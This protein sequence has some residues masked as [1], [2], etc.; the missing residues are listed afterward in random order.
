MDVSDFSPVELTVSYDE[1][2]GEVIVEGHLKERTDRMGSIEKHFKRKFALPEDTCSEALA[3]FL[4]TSKNQLQIVAPKKGIASLI[5]PIPIQIVT[6]VPDIS[7]REDRNTKSQKVNDSEIKIEKQEN[8]VDGISK[9]TIN[10]EPKSAMAEEN[11]SAEITELKREPEA[12]ESNAEIKEI[13]EDDTES[14]QQGETP[15]RPRR[16]PKIKREYLNIFC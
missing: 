8:L 4:V 11:I 2:E 9:S 10:E 15:A 13:S 3:A 6:E 1:A 5:R 12:E 7:K 16:M 14:S